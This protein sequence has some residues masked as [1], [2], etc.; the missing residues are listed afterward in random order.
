MVPL[1]SASEQLTAS[2]F[3]VR[4]ARLGAT[5]LEHLEHATDAVLDAMAESGT[6]AVLLPGASVFLGDAE[7]PPVAAMRARGVRMALGTDLNPGTSPLTNPWLVATLA[8]TQYGLLPAE[9][10]LGLTRHAAAALG[11]DAVAGRLAPG[12]RADFIVTRGPWERLL[13]GLGHHP[14]AAVHVAGVHQGIQTLD[15]PF[16]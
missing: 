1:S 4:A 14:V 13:Y 12:R 3:G 8:C 15:A 6:V 9:A 11:L 7:R 16:R 10:L 5:S 2:G